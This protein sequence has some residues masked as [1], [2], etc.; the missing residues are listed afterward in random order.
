MTS[1]EGLN[2]AFKTIGTLR[3]RAT[4]PFTSA[5]LAQGRIASLLVMR[6]LRLIDGGSAVVA[7]R[8]SLAKQAYSGRVLTRNPPAHQVLRLEKLSLLAR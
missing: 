2:S 1:A 5:P 7:A 3:L 6:K 4:S 8:G